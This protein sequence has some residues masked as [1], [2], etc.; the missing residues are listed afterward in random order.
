M[1]HLYQCSPRTPKPESSHEIKSKHL[2]IIIHLLA[3]NEGVLLDHWIFVL[4]I[5]IILKRLWHFYSIRL[6][7][8]FPVLS[9]RLNFGSAIFLHICLQCSNLW[10]RA[11]NRTTPFYL[12]ILLFCTRYLIITLVQETYSLAY[13][14]Q[15]Q[16]RS[17]ST[18]L[19]AQNPIPLQ[20]I[21]F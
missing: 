5:N 6:A 21:T 9:R 18:E 14:V 8:F 15:L 13:L 17:S 4:Q 20:N 12:Y 1:C 3:E 19:G 16:E 11:G 10:S 2:S 7:F